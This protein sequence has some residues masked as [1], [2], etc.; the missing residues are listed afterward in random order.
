M[1]KSNEN[2]KFFKI[3]HVDIVMT[4]KDKEMSEKFSEWLKMYE[5]ASD[6]FFVS[7]I[8]LSIISL[9]TNEKIPFKINGEC[10]KIFQ[11]KNAEY[12]SYK[13]L[14]IVKFQ[15]TGIAIVNRETYKILTYAYT[16]AVF[17]S[18]WNFEDFFHPLFEII[19][20]KKLYPH[21]SASLSYNGKGLLIPGKSGQGKTTLSLDLLDNG[22][23][24]S[25]DDRCFMREVQ[26]EEQGRIEMIGFYEPLRVFS[27]NVTHI[28]TLKEFTENATDFSV[29]YEL[30]IKKIYGNK[31]VD[32]CIL[33]GII[34]PQWSPGETSRLEPMTETESLIELLPLSMVC[35]DEASTKEHFEFSAKLVKQYP[36]AKLFMGDDKE[37]WHKLVIEFI[38]GLKG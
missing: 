10:T 28:E 26:Y 8:R 31:I 17:E 1:I 29:K 13:K 23:D 7:P 35:F 6:D 2:T 4:A 14:W 19:R 27:S 30:D 37:A 32:K 11:S 3:A 21:H 36:S 18:V 15:D 25:S 20:Q 5:V 33:D 34:F 22:F 9:K 38:T 16:D 12:F 24:F